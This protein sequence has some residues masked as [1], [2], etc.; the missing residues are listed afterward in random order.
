MAND[1]PDFSVMLRPPDFRTR[2]DIPACRVAEKLAEGWKEAPEKDRRSEY[3]RLTPQ[4]HTG[5][6]ALVVA[7]GPSAGMVSPAV[8]HSF[9]WKHK[10]VVWGTNNLWNVLGGAPL[11]ADYAVVLDDHFFSA[12][13]MEFAAYFNAHPHTRLVTCFPPDNAYDYQY[14]P[15]DIGKL[16]TT[17]WPYV[18]NEYFNGNS[19]GCAAIQMAMHCGCDP[20]YLLGHD[21]TTFK[22]KTH[23]FG[24]RSS[25]E[26][27]GQ[28]PQGR[29]MEAGYKLLAK[30]AR[31]LGRTIYNLSP[32]SVL[33]CF[34][35]SSILPVRPK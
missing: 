32:I 25:D 13:R 27:T 35:R 6:P 30:H 10:A 12:W 20:I 5:R 14:I 31:T 18:E 22:G 7:S 2:V 17:E 33:D 19:S 1:H 26:L 3:H 11:S 15:I 24:C 9:V 21:L 16:P 28:Y 4:S 29:V 34:P 8:L 23:G